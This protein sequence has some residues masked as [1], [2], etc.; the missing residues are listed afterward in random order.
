MKFLV[1][2]NSM[3]VLRFLL[4]LFQ[5][6]ANLHKTEERIAHN[7]NDE[8]DTIRANTKLLLSIYTKHMNMREKKRQYTARHTILSQ[9]NIYCL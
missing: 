9:C 1:L 7:I 6:N 2:A 4:I 8:Q 5:N 3:E